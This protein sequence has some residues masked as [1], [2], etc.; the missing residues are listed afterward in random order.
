MIGTQPSSSDFSWQSRRVAYR[1]RVAGSPADACKA[2]ALAACLTI[3]LC[4]GCKAEVSSSTNTTEA[5]EVLVTDVTQQDVPIYSE[6]VGSTDGTV[7]ASIRAQV[8]GYLLKRNYVEGAFVKRGHV[9]FEIDP[10]KFQAAVNKARGE[11]EQARARLLKAELDVKRDTPLAKSGAVS[12]KE[13]DDSIQDHAAAKANVAAAQANLEQALLNLRFTEIVAPI[14][15]IVG[16]AKAQVGDL[17]GAESGELTSM[18]TLDPIRVYVSLSEQE[19]L[20]VAEMVQEHYNQAQNGGDSLVKPEGVPLQLVLAGDKVYKHPGGFSLLDRQVDPRTGTI[21][22][23]ALFPN[24]GNVLRPGQYARVRAVTKINSGA[25]LVPQRAV[26][27]LQGGHQVAVVDAENRVDIRPVKV[28][29]RSGN[30][31]II[32]HGVKP[33]ERVVLTGVQKLTA[34]MTVIPKPVSAAATEKT[35]AT[36]EDHT[37]AAYTEAAR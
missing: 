23:A 26:S 32:E 20:N 8:T 5:P 27:D 4:F 3:A 14:D 22:A 17:I 33:G 10:R 9:L 25:L 18:S 19:Y 35:A 2:S 34:G 37:R 6:W 28:G 1:H 24:P 7:N 15:G 31:W 36:P 11:L 13:L 12:Q 16:I 21:R 29:E 30:L